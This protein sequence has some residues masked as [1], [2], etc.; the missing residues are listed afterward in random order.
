MTPS[1]Q[2]STARE[3]PRS[4][5]H[6][7]LVHEAWRRGRLRWLLH[8]SQ[9]GVY[10][11]YRAWE[12]LDPSQQ[13]G[14]FPRVFVLDIGKRWGKTT[15]RFVVRVEDCIRNPGNS[16]RYAS[17]FQK[18]I[19]EIVDEVAQRVFDTC[20]KDMR[21][22]YRQGGK[23][24]G[25]N[26]PRRA[27]TGFYFPERDGK[28]SVL[29]LVGLDKDP[30]GL[31][32]RA[33]DGD[34]ISEAAF[35]RHLRYSVKNVLYHQYQGRPSARMCMESS[36]PREPDSEYDNHFVED[37]KKRGAY[38]Y[39]TI[40]DNPMLSHE[41]REEFIRAAGGREHPDCKIEYFNERV[42]DPQRTIVPEFDRARHVC[43]P[44]EFPQHALALTSI[45]PG[46]AH[47]CGVL[48]AYWDFMRQK[49]V[50][51]RSWAES[52][53]NTTHIAKTI[54]D[55]DAELWS[56]LEY[57]SNNAMTPNPARRVSD[58]DL[59]LILDLRSLHGLDVMPTA[60]DNARAALQE[61][62]NAFLRDD[63]EIIPQSGPLEA[64][65]NAGIWN[66]KRTAWEVHPVH[67][68]FD[69]VAALVYLWRAVAHVRNINPT[70]PEGFGLT[71]RTHWFSPKAPVA[72][73]PREYQEL[74]SAWPTFTP[75]GGQ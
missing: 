49:L 40:D 64:Q 17:A 65:L 28:V 51:Q 38:A 42:R 70:P 10:D 59:R 63:I 13:G 2:R 72:A 30:D 32:G 27:G 67:G 52:N 20:P 58:T 62:R 36:A 5:S 14:T 60:K 21:P 4:L 11:T 57:Y 44:A 34:D 23:A 75:G 71:R 33:S 1:T 55:T 56:I 43:F 41:E 48:W 24:D 74:A 3:D 47:L 39:R 18:N 35:V 73:V 46:V 53:A 7:E 66:E 61:L 6:D 8:S 45:D 69:C 29:K 54:T 22:R 15:K 25:D 16:Y 68:H 37:A 19:E 12:R 50:V 9:K 26:D 31:R